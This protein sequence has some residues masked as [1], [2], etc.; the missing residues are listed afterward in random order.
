VLPGKFKV[1]AN[2]MMVGHDAV[3]IQW[4]GGNKVL[5]WPAKY[6][7]GTYKLPTPAWSQRA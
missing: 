1:D 5:V 4:Q 2:G 6:A 3:T 7:T